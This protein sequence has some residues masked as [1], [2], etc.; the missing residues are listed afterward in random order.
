[1]GKTW[2]KIFG[3]FLLLTAFVIAGGPAAHAAKAPKR[4]IKK[5]GQNLYRYQNNFHFSVFLVTPKGIIVTDPINKGVATWLKGELKKRFNKPVKYLIYSHDHQDHSSGGN[6]FANTATV[7]AHERAK[8]DIIAERR[9][10]AVPDITFSDKMT[11]ELGG[12]KVDLSYVGLSHS[13][14]MIVMNFPAERTLYAC[15]FIVV[16]RV[17]WKKL[18]DS[19]FP[20]LI[21]AIKKVEGMDFDKLATCHG[22]VGVKADVRAN[23]IFYEDLYN[24]V[25]K[26]AQ[27]GKSLKEMKASIKLEKYKDWTMHKKFIPLNIEG[28]YN[29]I[30][31]H[32]RATEGS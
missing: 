19:Y 14:N 5:I 28:I 8:A 31:L 17:G 12:Q 22:K 4:S 16:K 30:K 23:R 25:L 27:A 15:D 13:D 7:V 3:S 9:P 2:M 20:D 6:V 11:V 26:A 24:A 32:R 10:T 18:S 21:H 1:M 29:Q